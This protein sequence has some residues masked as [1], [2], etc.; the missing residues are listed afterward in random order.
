MI[1]HLQVPGGWILA[2]LL[3][4]AIFVLL[5]DLLWLIAQLTGRKAMAQI[6][7]IPALSVGA[8]VVATSLSA[9]GVFNAQQP[10]VCM[11][12]SSS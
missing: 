5:R 10:P 12:S 8:L 6:M 11:S 3:V 7:H 1:A 4:L 9:I 2:T